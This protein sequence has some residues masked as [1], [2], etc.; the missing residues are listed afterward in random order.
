MQRT[1]I[2]DLPLH[3]GKSPRWLF[4]KMKLLSRE[5]IIAIV[6]DSGPEEILRKISD[7]LWFQALGCVLGFDW[8]SSGLTTTV[9]GAIKEGIRGIEEEIG[10]FV[11][12]GKGKVA[13]RTPLEITQWSEKTQVNPATLIYASKMSAKVDTAG[14]QDGF[15]LYHHCFFFTSSGRWAVI[16]QGMN[17][18]TRYARRY[19]WIGDKVES[20][21]CEPHSGICSDWKGEGLNMVARESEKARQACTELSREKPYKI[22]K[23]LKRIN[24]LKMPPSHSFSVEKVRPD[25]LEKT[26]QSIHKRNPKNFEEVLEVKGVGAK[27]IRALALVS[28]LIYGAKPSF[29]DPATYSFAY[30]GKDGHPYPV[31]KQ[32]YKES[33]LLLH[34]ALQEARVGRTEKI[35]AIRRLRA[36]L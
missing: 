29:K 33:I 21:V 26:L 5:I 36:F 8:H 10:L 6:S 7:P 30:G 34:K 17:E 32:T 1:G 13:L 22:I 24:N 14:L 12:G 15:Q 11:T 20:F 27:T 31:D 4:E 19:H 16:Q 35:K 25:R 28:D 3:Y 23:E 2:T 9:C 18:L